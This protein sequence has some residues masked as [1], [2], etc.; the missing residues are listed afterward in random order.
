MERSD[1][2]QENNLKK[3]PTF[4]SQCYVMCFFFSLSPA[5]PG[6]TV[7]MPAECV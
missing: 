2:T 7:L 3:K 5:E 1:E 4:K 6:I